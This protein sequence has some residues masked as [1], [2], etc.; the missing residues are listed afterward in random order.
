MMSEQLDARLMLKQAGV[1]ERMLAFELSTLEDNFYKVIREF[2]LTLSGEDRVTME[3]LYNSLVM[4][5]KSKI[6]RLAESLNEDP[7]ILAKMTTEDKEYFDAI[8]SATMHF[9]KGVLL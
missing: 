7:T 4:A 5:R 3:G 8:V 1:K 2:L 9:S 6:V